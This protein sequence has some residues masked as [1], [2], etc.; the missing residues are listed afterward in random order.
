MYSNIEIRTMDERRPNSECELV[1]SEDD[2]TPFSDRDVDEEVEVFATLGSETRY[3][4]LLLLDAADGPVC[5]CELEPHLEVGQSSISQSLSKLR[6]ADLVSRTK[7]GRWRY[8]EPTPK[9]ERLLET[10][11]GAMTDTPAATL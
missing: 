1:L 2:A 5:V 8:Y 11:P 4:I 3:R 7:E 6:K 9:A 10:V